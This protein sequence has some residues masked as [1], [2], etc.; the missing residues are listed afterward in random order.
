[1][2]IAI[3]PGTFDPPT[4]G[5]LNVI[6]RSLKIYDR[7]I[8][9][10]ATSSIK[11]TVFTSAE[12]AEMLKTLFAEEPRVEIDSFE[13]LLVDY[14]KKRQA[15]VILRGLRTVYDFEYE[16]QMALANKKLD[17]QIETVFMMTDAKYA[18][19]SS[20]IIK[21]V[22]RLAGETRGMLPPIVEDRLKKKIYSKRGK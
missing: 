16:F 14:V 15:N 2:R 19:H 10:V 8:V 7:V 11:E 4:Y 12:R 13:G 5:H 22:V 1:M 6:E 20:S 9:A 17:E 3:Y 21:E 18:F